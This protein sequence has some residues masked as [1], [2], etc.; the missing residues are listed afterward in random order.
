[1]FDVLRRLW[2]CSVMCKSNVSHASRRCVNETCPNTVELFV[3]AY[4]KDLT[5][6]FALNYWSKL[7]VSRLAP[8]KTM[9]DFN[10]FSFVLA[11]K[12]TITRI[13]SW[14][15]LSIAIYFLPVF[16]KVI[17]TANI[18]PKSSFIHNSYIRR[19]VWKVLRYLSY[20]NSIRNNLIN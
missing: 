9:N 3:P 6:H 5:A 12:Q 14:P 1:M 18:I 17:S 8:A 19:L 16:S 7:F 4:G 10:F 20:L 15:V 11:A 2:I 13:F